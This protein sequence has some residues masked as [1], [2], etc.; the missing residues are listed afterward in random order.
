MNRRGTWTKTMQRRQTRF[1]CCKR[2]SPYA[3]GSNGTGATSPPT[4]HGFLR[5]HHHCSK[6]A[7]NIV[8]I[9][10]SSGTHKW[11]ACLVAPWLSCQRESIPCLDHWSCHLGPHPSVRVFV[12]SSVSRSNSVYHR[13]MVV[14]RDSEVHCSAGALPCKRV[15]SL[16]SSYRCKIRMTNACH[17]IRRTHL[18]TD[19]HRFCT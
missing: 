4:G 1:W 13:G 18:N 11:D 14:A 5:H 17:A 8:D 19:E 3:N 6:T 15:I 12:P 9:E 2:L 7:L 10:V 16:E